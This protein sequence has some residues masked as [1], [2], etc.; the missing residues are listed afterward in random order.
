MGIICAC[1]PT[2]GGPIAA[3]LV[4]LAST[5]KP[6]QRRESTSK[7]NS[8]RTNVTI[9]GG[10]ARAINRPDFPKAKG[11]NGIGSFER[12]NDESGQSSPTDLWPEGYNGERDITVSGRRTPSEAGGSIPLTSITVKQEMRWTESKAAKSPTRTN[13]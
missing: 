11:D 7:N 1:L 9:G 2:V 6:S 13:T 3:M 8:M 4:K 10:S 12:L 5:S